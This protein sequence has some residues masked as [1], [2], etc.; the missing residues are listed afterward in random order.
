MDWRLNQGASQAIISKKGAL[1][2]IVQYLIGGL[3]GA[4]GGC[5][6]ILFAED[7]WHLPLKELF[8]AES[9]GNRKRILLLLAGT[10]IGIYDIW[11]YQV[12]DL[13][14]LG[15]L[16]LC[17]G[18]LSATPLDINRH[19]ISAA[20]LLPFSILGVIYNICW[21]DVGILIN[22]ISGAVLGFAVLGIPYLLRKGSVGMGDLLLLTICGLYAGFPEVIYLLVRAL[23]FMAVWGIISLVRKKVTANSEIPFA[24]FLL[25]AALI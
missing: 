24:P 17:I 13:N 4:L 20:L 8:L 15:H 12:I 21:M 2:L 14:F 7:R 23:V 6:A 5:I 19:E 22:S 18:L 9:H 10:L 11:L 1:L 25:L 16:L 3:L